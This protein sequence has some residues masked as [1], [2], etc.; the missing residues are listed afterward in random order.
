MSGTDWIDTGRGTPQG[1]IVSP[2]LANVYL[3]YVFDLWVHE[4]WR[5]RK[6]RGDMIIVRYADDFG[7]AFSTGG[8]QKPS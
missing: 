3:H 5:K 1:A 4:T 2:V 8:K 7:S 6:A